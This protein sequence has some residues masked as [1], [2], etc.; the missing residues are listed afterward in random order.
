MPE[1]ARASV[2]GGGITNYAT[3]ILNGSSRVAGNTARTHG[4]GIVNHASATVT[5]ND[6]SSITENRADS[7][8]DLY[9]FGGGIYC[10][11]GTVAGAVDGVNVNDNYVG[12]AGTKED[13]IAG[14]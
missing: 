8:D 14:C 7:D 4:G 3:L 12:S 11:G 2:R 13:N 9:G 5:L 1:P 6:S 10:S